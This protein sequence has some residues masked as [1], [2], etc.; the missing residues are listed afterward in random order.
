[1]KNIK[2]T[3]IIISFAAIMFLFVG[4]I[5]ADGEASGGKGGSFLRIPIGARSAGLG[6]AFTGVADDINGPYFNPAGLAQIKNTRIGGMYNFMSLDRQNYQATL[7]MGNEKGG[8]VAL[9]F[10]NFG[11]SDIPECLEEE[12]LTG[13]KFNDS[14]MAFCLSAG[15]KLISMLSLGGTAKY[16][17]H[18]IYDNKG[19]GF[20][21][22]LGVMLLS[23]I[24]EK[25]VFRQIRAGASISNLAGKL[26]W[27]TDSNHEDEIPAT[28]RFGTSVNLMFSTSELLAS[29]DIS[30][31]I[32]NEDNEDN[33]EGNT[34]VHFGAEVWMVEMLG[35]R[36]G[37][38]GED[39]NFGASLK[40]NGLRFDYAF[41]PDALDEGTTHKLGVQIQF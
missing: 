25:S 7:I 40:L 6:N 23:P 1:M 12:G 33:E 16:I 24:T 5:V 9:S 34:K 14:E 13:D 29:V 26:T 32:H 2:Y 21:F 41:C 37:L 31:I 35:F 10:T 20:A 3:K 4:S 18:S 27:D 17:I 30:Q 11:V 8:A 15:G 28:L 22:D 39:L 36:A 38:D 19:S